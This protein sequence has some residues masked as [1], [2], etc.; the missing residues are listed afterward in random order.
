MLAKDDIDPKWVAGIGVDG[1]SWPAIPLSKGG[2]SLCNTP[3][4]MDTRSADICAELDRNIGADRIFEVCGNPLQPAYA[5]PKILWNKRN[6]PEVY[7]KADKVLQSNGYI[8]YKL[9]GNVSQDICQVYGYHCFDMRRGKWDDMLISE[10]GVR[11]DLLPNIVP[12]H[13]GIGRVTKEASLQYGLVEGT[14][15]VAGGL[16]AACGAAGRGSFAQRKNTG[17]GRSGC[18]YLFG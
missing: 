1:Q 11:R 17:T 2:E 6:L 7:N 8:A 5:L 16:D 15:V 12:C 4:W 9:T 14:P 18:F 10:M 3:I 13:G